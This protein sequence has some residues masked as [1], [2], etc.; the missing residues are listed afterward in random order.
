MNVVQP[1]IM[2]TD[3]AAAVAGELP[4]RDAILD[5]YPIR[6]IPTLEEVAEAVCFLAGP[7]TG[8]IN[9]ETINVAGGFGI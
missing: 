8:Y 5:M 9:G 2:P 3:M 6:R 7:A 4:N 1:G